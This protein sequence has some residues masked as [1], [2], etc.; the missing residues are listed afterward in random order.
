MCTLSQNG[1]GAGY[2]T[3]DLQSCL[4]NQLWGRFTH[5]RNAKPAGSLARLR[6][7]AHSAHAH[8]ARQRP[9]CEGARSLRSGAQPGG[10]QPGAQP[11]QLAQR[12]ATCARAAR[13]A[14]RSLRSS[15]HGHS[16]SHRQSHSLKGN[17]RVCGAGK[18][19]KI[20][21]PPKK[22]RAC[23]LAVSS[24]IY[25]TRPSGYGAQLGWPRCR[26]LLSEPYT[27]KDY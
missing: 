13:A 10:E 23:D 5:K 26:V 8:P 15:A 19:P 14:S 6:G 16:Q 11:G 7:G 9:A 27:R 3:K 21:S 4:P 24:A 1:Y 22:T 2:V 17:L 25:T 12:R 18:R 20:I